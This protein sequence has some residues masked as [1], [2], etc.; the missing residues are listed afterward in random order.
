MG[1]RIHFFVVA[2]RCKECGRKLNFFTKAHKDLCLH[3]FNEENLARIAE[4]NE[5]SCKFC[6]APLPKESNFCLKC[7]KALASSEATLMAQIND[8]EHR[9]NERLFIL[10]LVIILCV[11]AFLF[12]LTHLQF[13]VTFVPKS[14]SVSFI[15]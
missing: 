1:H 3:C 5:G 4:E 8:V 2:E 10:I 9:A 15:S 14:F 7:G 11:F 13:E 6:G 12:I